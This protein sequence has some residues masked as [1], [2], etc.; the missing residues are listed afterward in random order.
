MWEMWKLSRYELRADVG[1]GR[2]KG[3]GSLCAAT[4]ELT[5]SETPG[6]GS[7][8]DCNPGG[9]AL[10]SSSLSLRRVKERNQGFQR[11]RFILSTLPT[12]GTEQMEL[13]TV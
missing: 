3:R 4:K 1:V 10:S 8:Q 9:L 5:G 13:G 6:R 11:K 7:N 2:E 12:T